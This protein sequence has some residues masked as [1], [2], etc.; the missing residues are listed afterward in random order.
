[1]GG[2]KAKEEGEK[3]EEAL[4]KH[5]TCS[6]QPLPARPSTTASSTMR[7]RLLTPFHGLSVRQRVSLIPA[8]GWIC[9][10]C[11][12]S[13][14]LRPRR[15]FASNARTASTETTTKEKPYYITTP[16]FY[17]NAGTSSFM[18]LPLLSPNDADWFSS[19]CRTP[20]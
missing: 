1:M 14:P 16:I 2:D 9:S 5:Q 11:R 18:Q 12:A 4:I 13:L 15:K 20:L 17:V 3:E 19:P 6:H 7:T 8:R 10:S